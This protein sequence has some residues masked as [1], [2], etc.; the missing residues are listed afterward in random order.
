MLEE[1]LKHD[2]LGNKDELL[3]LLFEG[4]N[5]SG[6]QQISDVKF[7]C[8]SKIFS[9]SRSFNGII[10]FLKYLSFINL[11]ENIIGLNKGE[12]NPLLIPKHEY[13]ELYYFYECLFNAL[14]SDNTIGSILNESNVKYNSTLRQ[15]YIQENKYSYKYFPIRNLLL[16]TGFLQRDINEENYLLVNK[17]FT[18]DFKNQIVSRFLKKQDY[19]RQISL[20]QL[21]KKI[22]GQELR[23]ES[24]EQFVLEYER[25]RL[26]EHPQVYKVA[27]I[28]EE[29]VNAGYD[30]ESF[31]DSDSIIIDRF[32]E[33]KSYNKE[34][35]FYWSKNE[36]ETARKLADKYFLYLVDI[37]KITEISYEPKRFQD[38]YRRI[39]QSD[40][41]KKE[42][43]NWKI[44]YDDDNSLKFGEYLPEIFE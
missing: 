5:S 24:A 19:R 3:L 34:I 39:F 27:R 33:V 18:G 13:F 21:K 15:Y 8:S 10:K 14:I 44:I 35:G 37:N 17:G 42:T 30:I 1:V 28:S 26:S 23:G 41:W 22:L 29:F 16:S 25:R 36:V 6:N 7:Y 2:K 31:S 43:E 38:P 12:F 20:E 40:L 32:I 11:S 9:I 4:I